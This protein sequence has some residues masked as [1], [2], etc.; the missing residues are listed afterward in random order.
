MLT[1]MSR[2][3]TR[4]Q[5]QHGINMVDLMMWL[6]IAAMLLSAALQGIGYYQQA[7]YVYQMKASVEVAT[8]RIMAMAA[9]EGKLSVE[10]VD[11]VVAEENAARPNGVV[12]SVSAVDLSAAGE[13]SDNSGFERASSVSSTVVG[14]GQTYY[15]RAVHSGVAGH[16]VIHLF[17]NIA[18]KKQGTY[19]VNKGTIS[20]A[21]PGGTPTTTPTATPSVT[22][23][24][25]ATASPTV[26][27]TVTPT[28][29]PTPT[30]T[31]TP[32]PADFNAASATIGSAAFWPEWWNNE[33]VASMTSP[34]IRYGFKINGADSTN[35]SNY[36]IEYSGGENIGVSELVAGTSTFGG[37]A[38]FVDAKPSTAGFKTGAGSI[39]VKV[40]NLTTSEISYKTWPTTVTDAAIVSATFWP[41]YWNNETATSM[42]SAPLRFGGSIRNAATSDFTV[43][44]TGG[45]EIG[46]TPMTVGTSTMQ[47]LTWFADAKP[48][49]EGFKTGTGII[50]MTATHNVTGAVLTKAFTLTVT[51]S[52]IT[53]SAFWPEWWNNES[54]TAGSTASVRFGGSVKN[55]SASDFTVTFT[56]DDKINANL[57]ATGT[58]TT[59]GLTWFTDV[60]PR[61]GGLTSGTETVTM[62]VRHNATGNV[63]TK[64]FTLTVP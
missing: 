1:M 27:P 63:L 10:E 60:T 47:G 30:P 35:Q 24:P 32:P 7:A 42:T 26:T 58:S 12:L 44:F 57:T 64:V 15:I 5:E 22:A 9:N 62:T 28:P 40:T 39:T 50:T 8:S 6:V 37:M 45:S 49:A 3:K 51:D 43:T 46:V 21:T 17:S 53:S 54:A 33:T 61:A 23:T 56:G 38:W 25:S 20:S 59:S 34:A 31:V 4:I 2:I 11:A 48:G 13:S 36:K 52:V 14:S 55:A 18:S 41:E 29:T 19:L 16:D